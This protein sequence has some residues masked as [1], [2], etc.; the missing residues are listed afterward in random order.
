MEKTK[1]RC[2]RVCAQVD[3]LFLE[4]I[5]A[6]FL[7]WKFNVNPLLFAFSFVAASLVILGVNTVR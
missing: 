1:I 6:F 3:S 5:F 7:P 2:E 4:W